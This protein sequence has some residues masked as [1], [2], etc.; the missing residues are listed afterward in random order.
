[1]ERGDSAEAKRMPCGHQIVDMKISLDMA[2]GSSGEFSA[3]PICYYLTDA[4]LNNL[5]AKRNGKSETGSWG[6]GSDFYWWCVQSV[7]C[8]GTFLLHH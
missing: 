3:V 6:A 5:T 2:D 4:D 8:L 7:S 1:M